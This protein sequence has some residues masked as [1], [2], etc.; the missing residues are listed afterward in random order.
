MGIGSS[1]LGVK[2]PGREADHPPPSSAEVEEC[3]EL[4]L[5][6]LHALPCLCLAS[7]LFPLVFPTNS[8]CISHLSHA[9][10]TLF[11]L[12]MITLT[13]IG[14]EEKRRKYIG[15]KTWREKTIWKTKK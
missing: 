3:V 4:Y 2:R 1:F 10:Y 11:L 15:W 5:H 7:G 6:S 12:D 13:V 8:F 14:E 9:F